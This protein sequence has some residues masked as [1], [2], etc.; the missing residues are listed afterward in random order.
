MEERIDF[1]DLSL[2]DEARADEETEEREG[3]DLL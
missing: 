1:M 2:S 3:Y